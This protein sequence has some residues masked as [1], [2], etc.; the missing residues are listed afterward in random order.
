MCI[1]RCRACRVFKKAAE[2]PDSDR[3]WRQLLVNRICVRSIEVSWKGNIE[4]QE[5]SFFGEHWP[6][7]LPPCGWRFRPGRDFDSDK[8]EDFHNSWDSDQ[9]SLLQKMVNWPLPGWHDYFS[10]WA[11]Q[12]AW[13]WAKLLLATCV[14]AVRT[15][16]PRPTSESTRRTSS[17]F[18]TG[19]EAATVCGVQSESF[20]SQFTLDLSAC[21][22]FW[23]AASQLT[24]TSKLKA[25]LKRTFRCCSAWS[26]TTTPP[27]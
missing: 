20:R 10:S 18:G 9:R 19:W 13:S 6:R 3:H 4:W 7:W 5:N 17:P 22:I 23:A 1:F 25:A 14:L 21:R 16:R 27:S 2:K 8:F 11:R 12:M 15:L 26:G 24:N